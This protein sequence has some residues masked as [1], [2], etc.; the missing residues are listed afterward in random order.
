MR[1]IYICELSFLKEKRSVGWENHADKAR[2]NYFFIYQSGH[3]F[4][5]LNHCP[6]TGVNLDWTEHQFLDSSG[7]YIQ[8]ATHGALFEIENGLCIRG[9]CQRQSLI[10]VE[11]RIVNDSIYLIL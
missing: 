8:C 3:V 9:P 5:Y 4:S 10:A 2:T 11:N 6:H 1:E 7:N